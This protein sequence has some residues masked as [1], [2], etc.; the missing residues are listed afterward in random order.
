MNPEQIEDSSPIVKTISAGDTEPTLR[1][2]QRRFTIG[3]LAL[4]AIFAVPLWQL[5]RH[6]WETELQSHILLIPFVT[7]YL[8]RIAKGKSTPVPRSSSFAGVIAAVCGLVVLA[9]YWHWGIHHRVSHNDALSLATLSFLLFQLANALF[10]LG[11][12]VLSSRFFAVAF[13]VF[14]IPLPSGFTEWLSVLL[15]RASAEAADLMLS[16]TSIPFFR[17]GLNFQFAGLAIRV[18]EECSGVRSTFVLFITSLLAGH[19]FLRS[20]WKKAFLALAIFPLGILRNAFRITAISWLTVNVDSGIIDSPL[21]HRGG[22]IFFV[23]SLIPLFALLW[24]LR[25]SDF[26]KAA[27]P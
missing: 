25:R 3:A 14:L 26:P 2:R 19:L 7:W 15:Q 24:L 21:H 13:L 1:L 5:F 6:A 10:T 20:G 4:A 22:P 23:L 17:N 12:P 8:I 18:A 11:W 9:A 16:F 27:R